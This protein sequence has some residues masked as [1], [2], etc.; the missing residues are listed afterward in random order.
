MYIMKFKVGDKV[1]LT[2]IANWYGGVL[3]LNERCVVINKG[4]N[5]EYICDPV[6]WVE[7]T[8]G[9]KAAIY[10]SWASAVK[11]KNEQLLFSFME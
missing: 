5:P 2:N 7:N 4:I 10:Q 3:K 8:K 1:V 11:R 6:I 9:I